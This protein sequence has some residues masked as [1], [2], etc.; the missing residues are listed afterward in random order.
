MVKGRTALHLIL[1]YGFFR[2]AEFSVPT[3]PDAQLD[4]QDTNGV[5]SLHYAAKA[6]K[7]KDV[8]GPSLGA[9]T[10]LADRDGATHYIMLNSQ[11]GLN[12]SQFSYR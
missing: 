5:T 1:T 2:S 8:G 12:S 9:S 10:T 6:G 3:S 4:S 7:S 11:N